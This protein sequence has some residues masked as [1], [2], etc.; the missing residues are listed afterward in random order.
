M[1]VLSFVNEENKRF[2]D[3]ETMKRILGVSRSKVQREIK[4]N[5]SKNMIYKNQYLYSQRTLFSLM[6]RV[7][8][9]KIEKEING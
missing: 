7:L 8:I 2:Y 9:E 6:E 4:K 3:I 5:F 1:R